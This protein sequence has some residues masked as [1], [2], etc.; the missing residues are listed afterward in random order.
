MHAVDFYFRYIISG[1]G[2]GGAGGA[3]APPNILDGGAL[4]PPIFSHM[5]NGF[6]DTFYLVNLIRVSRHAKMLDVSIQYLKVD[7]V[8]AL[9]T[10]GRSHPAAV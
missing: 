8:S 7:W 5:T 4:P 6:L 9:H 1:V 2:T 10:G 3:A